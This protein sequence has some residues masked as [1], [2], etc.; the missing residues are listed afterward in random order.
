M[1]LPLPVFLQ[2]PPRNSMGPK[3][4]LPQSGELF[5]PRLDE[6]LNMQH[7]LVRLTALIDWAEIEGTSLALNQSA[8]I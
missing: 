1:V 8:R 5:R 7:P 4:S 6:Q 3:P 2:I